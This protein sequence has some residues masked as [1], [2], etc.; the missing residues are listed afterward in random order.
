MALVGVE[1]ETLISEPDTLTIRPPPCARL[2]Y[3][4][5]VKCTYLDFRAMNIPYA[6]YSLLVVLSLIPNQAYISILARV[7][8]PD[9][10]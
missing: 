10:P 8:K 3:I 6:E 2:F 1:I 9:L 7:N 5:A 4:S